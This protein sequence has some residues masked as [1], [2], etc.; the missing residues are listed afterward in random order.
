MSP[1]TPP[2]APSEG[3]KGETN[4]DSTAPPSTDAPYSVTRLAQPSARSRFQPTYASHIM[5][6]QM[7]SVSVCSRPMLS[8]RQICPS[9][10]TAGVKFT[11]SPTSSSWMGGTRANH[12]TRICSP[13]STAVAMGGEPARKRPS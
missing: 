4:M 7:C 3:V 10:S 13:T 5:L 6:R 2:E 12:Q 1:K 8:G 9:S 11:P